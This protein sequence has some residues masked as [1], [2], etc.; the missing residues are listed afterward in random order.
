[1]RLR[2]REWQKFWKKDDWNHLRA[3]IEGEPATIQVWING[4]KVLDWTDFANHLPEKA[5]DGMIA[6]QVHGS[7]ENW[8]RWKVGAFHRFRNI[9]VKELN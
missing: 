2:E 1:V 4:N 3:R 5:R 8:S 6:V 7:G 9:A